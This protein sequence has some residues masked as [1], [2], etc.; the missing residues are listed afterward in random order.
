VYHQLVH[1][2]NDLPPAY[3]NRVRET[4]QVAVHDQLVKN[5]PT[6]RE[7]SNMAATPYNAAAMERILAEPWPLSTVSRC[8]A[9][10]SAPAVPDKHVVPDVPSAAGTPADAADAVSGDA[11]RDSQADAGDSEADAG[12][13]SPVDE[14]SSAASVCYISCRAFAITNSRSS[15]VVVADSRRRANVGCA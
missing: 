7:A 14:P 9:V 4:I 12:V 6:A 2:W 1:T 13:V 8:L 3:R 5:N 15:A 11:G 10:Q